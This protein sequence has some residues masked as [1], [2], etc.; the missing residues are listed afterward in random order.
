MISKNKKKNICN[1]YIPRT[2]YSLFLI[3][4]KK[5]INNEEN[6]VVINNYNFEKIPKNLIFFL[7]K[8][9]FK[10]IY[11]YKNYSYKNNDVKKKNKNK[12]FFGINYLLNLN[13]ISNSILNT[14]YSELSKINFDN[15][16]KINI[17]YSS[18]IF[19]FSNF[20]KKFKNVNLYF[21][22]HG[23]GNF[24]SFVYED[25]KYN[26]DYKYRLKM[27]V[28]SLIFKIKGIYIPSKSFYFGTCFKLFNVKSLSN[29][30]YTIEPSNIDFRKGFNEIFNFY[31]KE[32]TK[33]KEKKGEFIYLQ[34]PHAYELRAYKEF[35]KIVSIKAKYNRN[36]I[37]IIK[38]KSTHS[39]K[40]N[41]Y[42]IYLKKFFKKEKINYYFLSEKFKMIPAEIILEFFK[43]KEIYS[44]YSTILFSPFY[45][46]NR[47]I[48]INAF[49]SSL[50][51]KKYRNHIELMPF[52]NQFIKKRY[53]NKKV[54]YIDNH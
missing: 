46:C 16:Q 32:L 51:K 8:R 5:K 15:Y 17:Y 33:I 31:K 26:Y 42:N 53:I 12:F 30:N 28:T 27:F 34:L 49:F 25:Y 43:V 44:A 48:K 6:F 19:Y 3:L 24:L 45:F 40:K 21:L 54:N 10:I 7:K 22:E 18:N 4:S 39:N 35:L 23:S 29:N 11:I 47:Q 41:K 38:L 2:I 37:F 9:G 20:C 13:E 14:N 50:I 52:I 36:Y 1:L